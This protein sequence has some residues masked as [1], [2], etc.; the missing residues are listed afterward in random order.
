M[1]E[2]LVMTLSIVIP[3]LNEATSIESSL[4]ALT[5]LRQSGTEVIVVD[6]GS[7]DDTIA[8]ARPFA[9]Q[10]ISAPRGRGAQ[11]NAGAA[12]ARGDVLLFLH[13]DTRLPS[14]ADTLIRDGLGASGHVWGRFDVAIA[15]TH[16]FLP[17]IATM[18]NARSRLTGIVTG[19]QAMFVTR[20][21]FYEAGGF[22][23]IPLMEDIA[24]ARKL[25]QLSPPLRLVERV[26]TSGRR[27]EKSGVLRTILL[28]WQLRLSFWLGADP[29][30]L[31]RRYGYVPRA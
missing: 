27:W 5:P 22:P 1:T 6:G 14:G 18:I 9:D 3:V 15:G 28:M 13:S 21:A 26:T 30:K 8:L 17:V 11:M 20:V 7:A 23:D 10:V 12:I 19:D 16:P 4:A 2:Y 31:A 29:A 25:K 24:L